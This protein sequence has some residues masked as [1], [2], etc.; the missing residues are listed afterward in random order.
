MKLIKNKVLT[1]ADPHII[2]VG[3]KEFKRH[4]YKT[5]EVTSFHYKGSEEPVEVTEIIDVTLDGEVEYFLN[6]ESV[7]L[8][9]TGSVYYEILTNEYTEFEGMVGAHPIF[10]RGG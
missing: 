4:Y 2:Q 8:S 7:V 1:G 9:N 5:G 10:R 3:T 6:P